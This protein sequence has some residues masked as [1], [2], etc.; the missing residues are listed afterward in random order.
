VNPGDL[1]ILLWTYPD[2]VTEEQLWKH[3]RI[4]KGVIRAFFLAG[5]GGLSSL[6]MGLASRMSTL[7]IF[8]IC[9]FGVAS[10][11]LVLPG[12][13]S[14]VW[15]DEIDTALRRRGIISRNI[16]MT[17]RQNLRRFGQM[18]IWAILVVVLPLIV[19]FLVAR[20]R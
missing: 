20:I 18:L 19:R 10:L 4:A 14:F 5:I 2:T 13:F 12:L 3:Y 8:I 6:V 1:D 16:Q 9:L 17:H 15:L 7:D 11:I